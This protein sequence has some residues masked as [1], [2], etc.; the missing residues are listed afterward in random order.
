[1][2]RLQSSPGK[3]KVAERSVIN[4]R[5]GSNPTVFKQ[6]SLEVTSEVKMLV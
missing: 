5:V 3:R 2:H 6:A 4:A 1:M